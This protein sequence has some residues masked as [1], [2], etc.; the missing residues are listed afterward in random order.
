MNFINKQ[1]ISRRKRRQQC[2]QISLLFNGRPGGY[3]QIHAH[4]IGDNPRQ[5]C[6]AQTRR[7]VQQYMIQRFAAFFRSI[8]INRKIFFGFDL[9][10]IFPQVFWTQ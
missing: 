4:F 2:R 7:A 10:N 5:G 8:H 9:S 3:P 6:F 1:Y